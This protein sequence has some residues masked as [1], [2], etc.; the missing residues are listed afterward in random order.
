MKKYAVFYV[1]IDLGKITNGG[2]EK[3]AKRP[4]ASW[5]TA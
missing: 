1:T 4:K 2:V 3:D 5:S